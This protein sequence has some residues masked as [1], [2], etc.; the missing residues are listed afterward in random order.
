[1]QFT[2]TNVTDLTG[3]PFIRVCMDDKGK[4]ITRTL[5][6]TQFIDMLGG[7][8]TEERN[9]VLLKDNFFPKTQKA[10]WFS[11]YEN[12]SCVWEEPAKNRLLIL[13]T[14]LGDKHFHVP[15]PKLVFKITVK[16]G[17]VTGKSCF[18][19]K[20]G[21]SKLFKYPFGNVSPDGGI[22]MGN[23]SAKEMKCVSEFS[24]AFF[25]G[26]T[27]N[28]Y[29]GSTGNGKVAVEFS[30]EQLLD[31]LSELKTFPDNFLVEYKGLTI[32]ELCAQNN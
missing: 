5:T 21:S 26:V 10:V 31:K 11:D 14:A 20:D 19:M 16:N 9:Y 2:A 18:A 29:Y 27:N 7:S 8:T 28:D 25:M 23:I 6:I 15:F 17:Q 1:M 30:Q 4:S 22:C 12:Y 13:K 3:H 24:D 32:K